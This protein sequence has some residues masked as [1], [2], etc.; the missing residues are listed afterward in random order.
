MTNE[1][2]LPPVREQLPTGGTV[3][4][5]VELG[6]GDGIGGGGGVPPPMQH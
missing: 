1:N 2:E 3:G 4:G 5:K 6:G